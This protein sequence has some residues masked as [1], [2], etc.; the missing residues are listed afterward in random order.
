MYINHPP[1]AVNWKRRRHEEKILYQNFV[2]RFLSFIPIIF[3][4]AFIEYQILKE[5]ISDRGY[6]LNSIVL[7]LILSNLY[8]KYSRKLFV[9]EASCIIKENEIH[10]QRNSKV[11]VFCTD[12]IKKCRNYENTT[13][14][15]M[16]CK[17]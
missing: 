1:L 13:L 6:I 12:E 5:V 2:I 9:R 4:L 7:M 10:I 16:C 17:T 11:L 8:L 15:S 3:L 14:W